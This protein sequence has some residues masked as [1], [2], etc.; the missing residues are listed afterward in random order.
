[1]R[2]AQGFPLDKDG[3][4]AKR[5][6][7]VR[8]G[9]AEGTRSGVLLGRTDLSL[10]ARGRMQS[11]KLIGIVS[12]CSE[13]RC[14]SSPLARARETA[15]I[16]MAGCGV[17]LDIDPDLREVDFGDWEGLTFEEASDR[18]AESV[19]RWGAFDPG[20]AF[21]GGESLKSFFERVVTAGERLAAVEEETAVA[22]THG[23]V[24]RTLLCHFLGLELRKY[25]LFDIGLSCVAA[26][27]LSG[28]RGTLTAFGPWQAIPGGTEV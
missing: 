14:F 21:P 7:L 1:M 6:L 16:A 27:H 4:V 24:I 17:A 15:E 12:G 9:E 11:A 18:D 10:S 20:F 23:G 25:V 13:V 2:R 26:V 22:F 3:R 8:H 28:G 19:R 5:I